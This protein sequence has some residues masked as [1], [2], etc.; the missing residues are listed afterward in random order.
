MNKNLLFPILEFSKIYHSRTSKY[1]PFLNLANSLIFRYQDKT[2]YDQVLKSDFFE[3]STFSFS[4]CFNFDFKLF[5]P[6]ITIEKNFQRFV[7]TT[8][9]PQFS[10]TLENL[11]IFYSLFP[12]SLNLC[13]SDIFFFAPTFF[14]YNY[15]E[16]KTYEIYFSS[17]FI[18]SLLFSPIQFS[19]NDIFSISAPE[20]F[21]SI[22]QFFL[23]TQYDK[24]YIQRANKLKTSFI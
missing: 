7:T 1:A 14:P 11:K 6:Q 18:F 2:V 16:S 8:T 15:T 9:A 4:S 20:S 24:L 22:K 10:S 5:Y 19:R 12:L 23:T 21:S 17:R 13:T 3:T